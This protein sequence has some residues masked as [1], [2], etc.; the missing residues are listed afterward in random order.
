MKTFN[1]SPDRSRRVVAILMLLV[2]TVAAVAAQAKQVVNINT[3]N[4]EQLT[5]LPRVGP[6]LARRII[7]H[8]ESNGRFKSSEDLLLVRGIGEST[9]Q[10]LEPYVAVDGETTLKEPV[11]VPR[12]SG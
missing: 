1:P 2:L 12:K 10:L 11:S 4:E 8:R 3:A 6:S 5:L 9:Y 7:E